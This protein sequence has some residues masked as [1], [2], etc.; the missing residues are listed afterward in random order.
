MEFLI[1]GLIGIGAVY[2]LYKHIRK[3]KNGGCN[4]SSSSC[5]SCPKASLKIN[6]NN[7]K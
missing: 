7:K 2:I 6:L 3:T 1:A 5:G 4:C